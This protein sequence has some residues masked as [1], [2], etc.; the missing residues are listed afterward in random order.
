MGIGDWGLGLV[1]HYLLLIT[2]YLLLIP[3]YLLLITY[4]SL[5]ITHYLLLITYYSYNQYFFPHA[6]NRLISNNINKEIAKRTVP[7]TV[8]PA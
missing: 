8:A 3:H 7:M 4:Y 1:T 2:H 6:C 5:L